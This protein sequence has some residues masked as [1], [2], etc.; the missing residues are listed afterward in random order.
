MEK[1]FEK[2][3]QSSRGIE[4]EKSPE[5]KDRGKNVV[6]VLKILRH[7]ERTKEGE[8]T[9]Y[10][11]EVTR[12]RAQLSGLQADQFSAVKAIGSR[13][14]AEP[15]KMGRS[16]ETADIF[17]AEVDPQRRF[18]S[19]EMSPLSHK[20]L[21][22]KPPYDHK[23]I[24][25][26]NLPGN[27]EELPD[28]EKA[29]AAKKAQAATVEHLHSL[30]NPEAKKFKK[31]MAGALATVILS[32]V[33]MSS[34][35]K[36][37]YKA[38]MPAGTH[39]PIPEFLLK[40][41]LVRKF[42]DGEEI[43]GFEDTDEIGGPINPSESIEVL[44]RRDKNGELQ[45]IQVKFDDPERPRAKEMYLDLKTLVELKAFYKKLH[46]DEKSKNTQEED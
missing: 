36:S 29:T 26:S 10:G 44:I 35:L 34:S 31:E 46:R 14:D 45:K 9:D 2:P 8:L 32:R 20:A 16:L 28:E 39:G 15:G 25:N 3:A 41:A 12:K 5:I 7:G 13:A 1:Q 21:I 19:R 40:E 37:G 24:Y 38:L 22:T 30:N 4:Q 18:T 23:E 27:F 42:E 11:R 33:R 17:A 43:K 6:I